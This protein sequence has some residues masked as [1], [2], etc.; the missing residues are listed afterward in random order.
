[1][2]VSLSEDEAWAF[3]ESSMTGIVTTMR[4]DGFPLALPVWFVALDHMIYFRTPG[5]QQEDH[6]YP[7]QQQD[8]VSGGIRRAMA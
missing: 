6:P 5:R 4:G 2:G 3:I 8:G 7:Q 1:M